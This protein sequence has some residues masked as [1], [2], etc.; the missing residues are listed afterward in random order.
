MSALAIVLIVL[1]AVILLLFVGGFVANARRI[2]AREADLRARIEAA[3]QALAQARAGD[4][5]WDLEHLQAA[6]RTA[7]AAEH[8]HEPDRLDLIQVVDK[9]GTEADEAVFRCAHG[10]HE[11]D[12]VLGREGDQW[13]AR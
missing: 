12:V 13:V 10:H 8:G 11:H 4:R 2:R 5:G 6:A 7:F 1:A 3:D 9:P